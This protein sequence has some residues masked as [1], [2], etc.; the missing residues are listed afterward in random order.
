[1]TLQH[2][3]RKLISAP[4]LPLLSRCNPTGRPCIAQTCWTTPAAWPCWWWA[5]CCSPLCWSW[6]WP[7]IA[8][9]PDTSSWAC[10]SFPTAGPSTR[11]C[12]PRATGG[13]AEEAAAAERAAQTG[14]G[15]VV[16]GF[17]MGR[18]DWM[19]RYIYTWF[20]CLSLDSVLSFLSCFVL[21]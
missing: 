9:W 16:C 3:S 5:S 1:M 19:C 10:A 17:R 14:R 18:G 7:P 21:L 15:R 4:L 13:E 8:D 11:T 12:L 6:L 20:C 2:V